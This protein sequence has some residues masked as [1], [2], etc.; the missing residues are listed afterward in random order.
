MPIS[1]HPPYD[2][3]ADYA[4]GA[5]P[6]SEHLVMA[7]HIAGCGRCKTFVLTMEQLAGAALADAPPV[8]QVTGEFTT[9][10]ERLVRSP[11]VPQMESPGL[12]ADAELADLPEPLQRCRMGR[13]RWVAPGLSKR[14]ILLTP[15][16]KSR[17]FLLRAQ[18][19]TRLI[20]HT[21][22]GDELTHVLKGSYTDQTDRY[23]P[24]DLDFSDEQVEHELVISDDGPCLCLVA[25][26]GDLELRGLLGRLIS[27]FVRL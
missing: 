12:E 8:P 4:V 3:L 25:M 10:M 1:H 27:P 13:W 17:A 19:S 11:Q 18:P 15:A 20:M 7:V 23:E 16:G 22:T 14:P 6:E 9:I 24:G 2:L 26:T 5:L 21:H